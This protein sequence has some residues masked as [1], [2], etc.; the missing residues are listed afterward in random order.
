MAKLE[1][2]LN[3]KFNTDDF[4]ITEDFKRVKLNPAQA[5]EYFSK[6]S[7]DE[8]AVYLVGLKADYSDA[9]VSF[10]MLKKHG[11]RNSL[12]DIQINEQTGT[13]TC[14]IEGKFSIPLRAG[15]AEMLNHDVLIAI[16]GICYKGGSYRGFMAYV[17]G[18]VEGK[19][20]N[21]LTLDPAEVS[22][23]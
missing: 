21:W 8:I 1:L 16:Q 5:N 7:S 23:K 9:F 2:N 20:E 17:S 6:C 10:E 12:I 4:E 11:K 15:V 22:V 3:C 13:L 14:T 19:Y 18:Q